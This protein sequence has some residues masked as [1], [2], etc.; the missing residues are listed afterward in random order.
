MP[1]STSPRPL[2]ARAAR[3]LAVAAFGLSLLL[4]CS[5][6]PAPTPVAPQAALPT[7][8]PTAA[9][10]TAAPSAVPASPSPSLS[11]TASPSPGP[12]GTGGGGCADCFGGDGSGGAGN[13]SLLG[14]DGRLT[15][16]LLGSDARP[17]H[18][19]T[20]T[21]TIMVASIDPNTGRTAV[22]SV[23][24][25]VARFPLA[26]GGS[27]GPKVNGLYAWYVSRLGATRGGRAMKAAV[28]RALGVEVDH[29]VLIGMTGVRRLIDQVGGV[30][31]YVSKTIRDP[32]YWV[33][34]T[35]RGVV[36]PRGWN[37]LDGRRALIFARTRKGDNDFERA[38][39]QQQLVAAAAA[40]VEQRGL[41]KLG[42][43]ISL[44]RRFVRTD[45]PLLQAP[46]VFQIVARADLRNARRAVLGP[47]R[48]AYSIGGSSYALRLSTVRSLIDAW[49]PAVK[50]P[51]PAPSPAPLP[52]P[53]PAG[54][55][56][57][58]PLP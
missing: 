14:R 47:S 4:A 17:S 25:D 26:S 41:E 34:A 2:P 11:A 36:F 3:R 5:T 43:I 38:R 57:S 45:L 42:T 12:G 18:P 29:Y 53:S 16:L 10:V 7:Q 23:P 1:T 9:P 33:S 27:Y 50:A 20:R 39:R 54:A 6:T 30:D 37:H 48:Y 8:A 19:G 22:V 40:A 35:R 24:R 28:G 58:S 55:P 32:Y 15:V 51:A 44:G 31:V 21:D 56:M 46:R 49:M 13:G 52:S